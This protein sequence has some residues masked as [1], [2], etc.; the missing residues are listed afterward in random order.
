M[1]S[2]RTAKPIILPVPRFE[3]PDEFTCG[4]TCLA[5]IYSYYGHDKPLA[6]IIADTP[7]N[8][9]GGTLAVFLGISALREGFRTQIYSYNLR[10]FDPTWRKLAPKA[11]L[12]K[13][14]KRLAVVTSARQRR[15]ISGYIDYLR[16][17]GRIR[18][19]ELTSHLLAKTL[20]QGRPILTGLNATYLY[21]TPREYEEEF[22]D[23]RGEPAGHFL[24]V[25]GYYPRGGRFVVRDPSTHI[26]FSRSGR[27]SVKA[28][29]LIS[30]ILLGDVTYDAVLLV[31]S[32]RRAKKR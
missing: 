31:V 23:V 16:S 8:P 15:A 28:E 7:R 24:V 19:A 9:D 29:R 14:H 21:G 13:L 3:Q 30:A 1:R 25:S 18:F 32:P 27:Y 10:V 22:D 17:G 6:E 12:G 26:P 11:L 2:K 5:Q 4:P 20:A